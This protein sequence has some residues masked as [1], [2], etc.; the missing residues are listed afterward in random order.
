MKMMVNVLR[1]N[2]IIEERVVERMNGRKF[3]FI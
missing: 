1:E 3:S 2:R